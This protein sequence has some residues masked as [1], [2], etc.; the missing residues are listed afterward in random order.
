MARLERWRGGGA[1]RRQI[2]WRR[3]GSAA[4]IDHMQ[5]KPDAA[6]RASGVCRKRNCGFA[7]ACAFG[8]GSLCKE[9]LDGAPVKVGSVTGFALGANL[10]DV[11][12]TRRSKRSA[13]RRRDR[14][15][16]AIGRLKDGDYAY[17]LDDIATVVEA[18]HASR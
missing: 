2:A 13:P 5:L 17:V 9:Q 3:G 11:K 1:W 15:C 16:I 14:H 18:A 8:L 7:S 10:T 12:R 4:L 6:R